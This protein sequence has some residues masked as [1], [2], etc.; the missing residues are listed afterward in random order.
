MSLEMEPSKSSFFKDVFVFW[1][2]IVIF[3][4]PM[5]LLPL[6]LLGDDD[7]LKVTYVTII[8]ASFWVLEV[9]PLAVTALL[10]VVL[11]PLMGIMST[12]DV[13]LNYM[14]QTSMNFFASMSNTN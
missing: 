6:P 7:K 13:A 4:L 1:K 12:G 3:I 5:A 10:P 11:F 2:T 8:M 14:T 9:L